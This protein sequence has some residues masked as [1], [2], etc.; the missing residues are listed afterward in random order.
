[1]PRTKGKSGDFHQGV[2]KNEK[3]GNNEDTYGGE[4]LRG[5]GDASRRVNQ[6]GERGSKSPKDNVTEAPPNQQADDGTS[7]L[8][9]NELN[10]EES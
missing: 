8:R 7:G 10:E 4:Q 3:R 9:S 6:E 1:M 5:P 2:E